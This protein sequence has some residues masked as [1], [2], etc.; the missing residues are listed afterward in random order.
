MCCTQCR[1]ASLVDL[2]WMGV[3]LAFTHIQVVFA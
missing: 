3:Q 1:W 2:T